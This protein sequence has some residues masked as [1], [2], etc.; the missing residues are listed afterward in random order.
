[1]LLELVP[2]AKIVGNLSPPADSEFF[3]EWTT[4]TSEAAKALGREVVVHPVRSYFDIEKA[5]V[6]FAGRGVG[7]ITV[8]PVSTFDDPRS[9]RAAIEFATLY[10]SRVT[11]SRPSRGRQPIAL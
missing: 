10:N 8:D 4:K 6:N 11:S 5:F 3:K 1:L 9:S 2:Q 7:G